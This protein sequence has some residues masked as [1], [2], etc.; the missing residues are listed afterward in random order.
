MSDV[1]LKGIGLDPTGLSSDSQVLR[2]SRVQ[3]TWD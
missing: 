2:V 3:R 1:C